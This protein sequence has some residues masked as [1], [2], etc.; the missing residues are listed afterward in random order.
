MYI[1][2]STHASILISSCLSFVGVRGAGADGQLIL[3]RRRRV[4]Y[5]IR[6]CFL[7]VMFVVWLVSRITQKLLNGFKHNLDG[8][9]PGIARIN[10]WGGTGI[11]G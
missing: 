1:H 2:Q 5:L 8:R 6:L 7:P 11:K 4:H 10:F 3:V 9:W